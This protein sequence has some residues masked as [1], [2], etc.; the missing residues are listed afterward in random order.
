M[1]KSYSSLG[2]FY[3]KRSVL[4]VA[5][6]PLY[7]LFK[8]WFQGNLIVIHVSDEKGTENEWGHLIRVLTY[9]QDIGTFNNTTKSIHKMYVKRI[10]QKNLFTNYFWRYNI[11]SSTKPRTDLWSIPWSEF[12]NNESKIVIGMRVNILKKKG[13]LGNILLERSR[14]HFWAA[15]LMPTKI[16]ISKI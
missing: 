16:F 4:S 11:C 10:R 7:Q 9:V 6:V 12:N 14:D 13:F 15:N 2:K 5:A 3:S 1:G 8:N